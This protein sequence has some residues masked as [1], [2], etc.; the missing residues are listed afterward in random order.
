MTKI[1]LE[2]HPA[3]DAAG[4]TCVV[5]SKSCKFCTWFS[6][7]IYLFFPNPTIPPSS[8][9]PLP[10]TCTREWVVG[11]EVKRGDTV[12]K[13]LILTPFLHIYPLSPRALTSPTYCY[14]LLYHH[15]LFLPSSMLYLPFVSVLPFSF[16]T[17]S[18]LSFYHQ[19]TPTPPHTSF[20][21]LTISPLTKLFPTQ[22]VLVQDHCISIYIHGVSRFEWGLIL[23]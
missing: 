23:S 22:L 3:I 13:I 17:H 15:F 20:S 19:K 9:V 12:A 14:G 5:K 10:P 8:I 11:R 7:S 6:T 2:F 21:L 4:H 16:T 1:I 18:L